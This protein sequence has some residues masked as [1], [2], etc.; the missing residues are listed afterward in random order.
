MVGSTQKYLF[1]VL[2]PIIPIGR[3]STFLVNMNDVI[4]MM[5]YVRTRTLQQ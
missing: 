3:N 2:N 5:E 1:L 4:N